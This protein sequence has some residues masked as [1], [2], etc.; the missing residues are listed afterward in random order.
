MADRAGAGEDV[1][2]RADQAGEYLH[3]AHVVIVAAL[4]KIIE[5][6]QDGHDMA[7]WVLDA[8]AEAGWHLLTAD[9]AEKMLGAYLLQQVRT[10][11][12]DTFDK[13]FPVE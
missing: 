9:D 11:P 10:G 13:G 6:D 7:T 2:K 4:T 1:V 12:I 8:L 5:P 3:D